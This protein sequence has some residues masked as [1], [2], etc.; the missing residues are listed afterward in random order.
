MPYTL[1]D[2]DRHERRIEHYASIAMAQQQPPFFPDP[3]PEEKERQRVI[4]IARGQLEYAQR[5]YDALWRS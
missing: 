5:A 4:E 1:E 2:L 3:T